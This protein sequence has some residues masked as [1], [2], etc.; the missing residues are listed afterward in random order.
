LFP[1]D[2]PRFFKPAN[3]HIVALWEKYWSH[4]EN[5]TEEQRVIRDT[6]K[7]DVTDVPETI[8]VMVGPRVTAIGD[9]NGIMVR[10]EDVKIAKHLLENSTIGITALIGHPGIGTLVH[11]IP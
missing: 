1:D 8:N 2:F 10:S 5:L 3:S 6:V 4:P 11:L 7:E 9:L